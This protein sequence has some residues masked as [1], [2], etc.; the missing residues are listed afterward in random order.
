ML[1]FFQ[2]ES[3]DYNTLPLLLTHLGQ[4]YPQ[5]PIERPLGFPHHMCFLTQQGSGELIIKKERMK[6]REGGNVLFFIRRFRIATMGWINNGLYQRLD[7]QV[8]SV[9]IYLIVSVS[10]KAVFTRS[11]IPRFFPCIWT[12]F[13]Y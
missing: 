4:D 10:G 5:E 8:L 6:V 3:K 7:L 9:P 13:A 1:T 2:A 12:N 11:A